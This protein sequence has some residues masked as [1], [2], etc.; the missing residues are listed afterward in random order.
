MHKLMYENSNRE[1]VTKYQMAE[2]INMGITTVCKLA[3]EAGAVRKIGRN[4]R[5][6]KKILL[7]YIEK[8]YAE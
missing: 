8:M 5:I 3:E 2:C 4:Y 7:S 1:L 6:N